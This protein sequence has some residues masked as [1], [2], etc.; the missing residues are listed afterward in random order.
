MFIGLPGSGKSTVA[1]RLV[2]PHRV[3]GLW[4][5]GA[6]AAALGWFSLAP[7]GV[8]ALCAAAGEDHLPLSLIRWSDVAA[9]P[10]VVD[11]I[12]FAAADFCIAAHLAAR[13]VT[14]V[15]F[16]ASV[17]TCRGRRTARGSVEMDARWWHRRA[18][19][20]ENH[21]DAFSSLVTVEAGDATVDEVVAQVRRLLEKN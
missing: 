19:M 7:F 6:K 14:A 11:N 4:S 17:D 9:L 18:A 20:I 2:G 10:V 3:A 16:R 13:R 12:R 8:D 1:Q 5:I 21:I 15:L